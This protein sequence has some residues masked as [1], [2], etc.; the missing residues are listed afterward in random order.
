MHRILMNKAH[1]QTDHVGCY[2]NLQVAI[3]SSIDTFDPQ[4]SFLQILN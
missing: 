3:G 1:G 4:F 2:R